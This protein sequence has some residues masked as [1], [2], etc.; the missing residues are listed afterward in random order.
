MIA[1]IA[2][3]QTLLDL[4]LALVVGLVVYRLAA[5]ELRRQET[6][7]ELRQRRD[8]VEQVLSMLD[9]PAGEYLADPT[10]D[11]PQREMVELERRALQ[12]QLLFWRDLAIQKALRDISY[13]ERHREAAEQLRGLAGDLAG[14]LPGS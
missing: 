7:R 12:A 2:W 9:G 10:L 6:V 1:T 8:A 14:R 13:P 5:R 4:A 3:D 11:Y